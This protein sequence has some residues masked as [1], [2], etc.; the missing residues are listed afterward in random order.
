MLLA[1]EVLAAAV[2]VTITER[3]CVA[4]DKFQCHTLFCVAIL[5]ICHFDHNGEWR[6]RQTL[7]EITPPSITTALLIK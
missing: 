6:G 2:V 5:F 7:C 3:K 4:C 1:V